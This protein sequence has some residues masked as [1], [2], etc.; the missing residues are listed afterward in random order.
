MFIAEVVTQAAW[1]DARQIWRGAPEATPGE[2]VKSLLRLREG[3]RCRAIRVSRVRACP[4]SSMGAFEQWPGDY[5]EV[6]TWRDAVQL[7]G[8]GLFAV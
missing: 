1:P 4:D 2:A 6:I 8:P 5:S 3:K 7:A